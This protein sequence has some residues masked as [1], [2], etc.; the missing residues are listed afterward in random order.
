M[1]SL[2]LVSGL[3]FTLL[4]LPLVTRKIG[5][6]NLGKVQFVISMGF[7]FTMFVNLGIPAYGKREVALLRED[8]YKVSK[9]V[10][11]MLVILC[12]TTLVT[13]VVYLTLINNIESFSQYKELY[14]IFLLNLL[15]TIFNLE[16]FFMGIEDQGYITLRTLFV[17]ILSVIAIIFLVSNKEN[18]TKYYF[19]TIMA[20]VIGNL[21]NFKRVFKY[22]KI[23]KKMFKDIN[24]KR[25]L[26]PILMLFGTSIATSI[27]ANLDSVMVKYLIN[28]TALGYYSLASRVGKLPLVIVTAVYTVFYPRLCSFISKKEINKYYSLGNKGLDL[29]LLLAF[30]MT[31]GIFVLSDNIVL[32]FGGENFLEASN[33]LKMFSFILIVMA[34]AVFTGNNLVIN[35]KEKV[36]MQGQ[37]LS[38]VLN[39][40]FNFT[41]IPIL[42]PV[43][44]A[45]G[46]VLAEV[47]A[48]TYRL[49]KGK[50]VFKNFSLF[51]IN[52]LKV[53]ISSLVMGLI[54]YILKNI[55]KTSNI[56]ETIIL[57]IVG[58]F[59]YLVILI[60]L[61]EKIIIGFLRRGNKT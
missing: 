59:S 4:A 51:D 50:E 32:L 7:Y 15:F 22:I 37:I 27:F 49:R 55:L 1:Y 26:S 31:V 29:S 33:I 47:T 60:L 14:N 21:F 42:G 17:Q 61:K 44:A 25:H 41:I 28:D 43:G 24:I 48:I 18:Y 34:Y 35:L 54:I 36:F 6:E 3:L 39:V 40:G 10:L 12:V 20:I 23:E 38:S 58:L 30:P 45:L 2:R 19:I 13:V 52:K 56:I 53:L 9:F 16:W 8:K 57:I 5:P 46:T 11:E